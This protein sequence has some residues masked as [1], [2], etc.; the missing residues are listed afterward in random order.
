M[1][2]TKLSAKYREFSY[3]LCP[4][5]GITSPITDRPHHSTVVHLLQSMNLQWHVIITQNLQFTL[6]FTLGV[7]HS[8]DFDKWIMTYAHHHIY[9]KKSYIEG[10]KKKKIVHTKLGV[11]PVLPL[12]PKSAI[13]KNKAS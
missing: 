13:A 6:A 4:H 12:T 5:M 7:V 10:F 1:F 2:T 8:K 11:Q 9:R 3:I